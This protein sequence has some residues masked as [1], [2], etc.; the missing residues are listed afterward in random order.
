VEEAGLFHLVIPRVECVTRTETYGRFTMEPLD[1]GLGITVGNALRRCLLGALPGAAITWVKIDG[2]DHEFSSIPHVK[3]DTLEFLL[4]VKGI[5]LR[6]LSD[7]P[8][9]LTLEAEGEGVVTAADVRAPADFEIVNTELPLATLDAA[10]AR[11][12]ADFNVEHGKGY[13]RATRADGLPVGA[14]PVDA[15]FS[16]VQRANYTVEPMRIGVDNYE[17]L[18]LEVW[19]DGAMTP[20]EAVSR[21]ASILVSQLALLADLAQA[22]PR[23]SDRQPLSPIAI[24]Q[25]QYDMAIETL[26][27]SVRAYNCLKR[28][29]VAKV[30]QILEMTEDELLKVKNFGRKSLE[31]LRERLEVRGFVTTLSEGR[32]RAR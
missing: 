15:I 23:A 2:V 9:I 10:E 20:I 31:E 1:N 26:E 28:A 25:K 18:V 6:P 11:L 13:Q 22:T 12:Q 16:P 4:N 3:E 7:R 17:R 8:G 14:I 30:G 27:L 29:G 21:A 32:P 5:R 19:T 24:P